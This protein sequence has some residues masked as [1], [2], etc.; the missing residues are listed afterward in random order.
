MTTATH[1]SD[2]IALHTT[3]DTT[4]SAAA[5]A[6]RPA[7]GTAP[8]SESE[9][10]SEFEVQLEI[11]AIASRILGAALLERTQEVDSIAT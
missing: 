2:L 3:A 10:S 8:P 4:T 6:A 5:D 11:Q 1:E 9:R 7:L